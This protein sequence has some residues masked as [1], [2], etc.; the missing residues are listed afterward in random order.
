MWSRRPSEAQSPSGA[1]AHE[2]AG[3]VDALGEVAAR[4]GSGTNVARRLL[5]VAPVALRHGRARARRAR[6]GS[7]GSVDERARVVDREDVGVGAG[8]ADRDRLVLGAGSGGTSYAGADVGLGRPVEV[9]EARRRAAAPMQVAQVL[10]RE[11]L[12]GEEHRA[13]ARRGRRARAARSAASRVRIEGTEYQIVISL[14]ARSTRRA[15][16]GRSRSPSGTSTTRAPACMRR[17][18]VED[19]EVEVE[20]RVA[21]EPVVRPR[22][23]TSV[24]GPVDE[25]ERVAVRDH[26]ALRRARSS[27]TCRGCRRGRSR[28]RPRGGGRVRRAGDR[29]VAGHGARPGRRSTPR[30][31]VV[32]EAAR[33]RAARP[34]P[35]IGAESARPSP[36]EAT[37]ARARRSCRGC[38]PGAAAGAFGS[39][40]T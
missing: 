28:S 26:H 33:R 31:A 20:R 29:R 8:P 38:R 30:L 6:R 36:V 19:R 1:R 40:G 16:S 7:P 24:G 35:S 34:R 37:Q 23:R 12:A 9:R 39:S 14:R 5:R 10:G 15:G 17:V 13:Q 22:R 18:E 3:A 11:H 2:V 21:R 32:R 27:P 4:R 25:G